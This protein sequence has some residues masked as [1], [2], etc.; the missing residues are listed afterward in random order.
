ML[1]VQNNCLKAIFVDPIYKKWWRRRLNLIKLPSH[2][3]PSNPAKH[4]HQPFTHSPREP[5]CW[6]DSQ[7]KIVILK[8][9]FWIQQNMF[10]Y[11]EGK[12]ILKSLPRHWGPKVS[13]GQVHTPYPCCDKVHCAFPSHWSVSPNS[14]HSPVKYWIYL[15]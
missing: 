3:F 11:A 8:E 13:A 1:R 15:F 12:G 14:L 7:S 10:Y 9:I 2:R 4:S 6:F 5:H